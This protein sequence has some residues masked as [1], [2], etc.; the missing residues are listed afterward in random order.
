MSLIKNIISCLKKPPTLQRKFSVVLHIGTEKTGTTTIQEFLQ[1]NRE[2]LAGSGFCFPKSIGNCNHRPLA[3]LCMASD[4]TNDF[5]RMKNFDESAARKKWK[6]ELLKSFDAELQQ[7]NQNIQTV[8]ISSEHFSKLLNKIEGIQTL[9]DILQNWF[10]EIKIIIYLRR[11]DLLSTSLYNTICR[12]GNVTDEI[13]PA[14]SHRPIYYN[15]RKLLENW[16]SVFGKEN[17]CPR[18]FETPDFYNSKLLSDFINH[19][20]IP[21]H[22]DYTLPE[23]KNISH[24]KTAQDVV[25]VFNQYFPKNLNSPLYAVH[26][27]TRHKLLEQITDKYPGQGNK[28]LRNEAIDFY[29]QFVQDNQKLAREWFGRERL[30]SEDFSMYPESAGTTSVDLDLLDTVFSV[31]SKELGNSKSEQT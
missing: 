2:L 18:I 1:I 12:T 27:K 5:F 14:I 13:L 8:L 25:Q 24:S 9:K 21:E 19:S 26:R 20:G 4:R 28:P 30:F 3:V 31:L 6:N 15:Y 7:L 23:N 22:L 11:Q 16:S 29:K 17:I 10:D